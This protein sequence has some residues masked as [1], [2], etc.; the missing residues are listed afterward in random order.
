[1]KKLFKTLLIAAWITHCTASTTND[2]TATPDENQ[3]E[4]YLMVFHKDEDHSLHAALS[5]DGHT[6]T[7]L[8]NGQPI[9]SG[10]TIAEQHGIR[11]PHIY[12]GPDGAFYLAMTDLHIFAQQQGLRDTE[13]QRDG[14]TYGWGNNRAL[15]LMKSFDLINWQRTNIRIDKLSPE[16]ENIGCAWA[17]ETVCDPKTGRIMIYF[18]MRFGKGQNKLYYAYVNQDYNRIETFPKI[19]FEYPKEGISAIDGDITPIWNNQTKQ[20]NYHLFYVA[21]DGPAGIKHAISTRI[22]GDYQYKPEWIDYEKGSCEAPTVWKQ[23]GQERWILMY[24]I[25]SIK[26]HNFGFVETTDFVNFNHMGRFNEGIMTT[27]NF[28]SPKHGAVVRLTKTE[29]DRLEQYW[30][31]NKH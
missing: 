11:D 5:R 23:I 27:T 2:N 1:M 30:Q 6:F 28:T 15:V 22:D 20:W 7:A 16:L 10:D 18:T 9:I 13:W 26:P 31:Q 17:P 12:R 21:Q 29:A 19:L 24:D 14:E 25:Y 8:N 4:A 3:L